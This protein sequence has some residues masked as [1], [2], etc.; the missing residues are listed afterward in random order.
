MEGVEWSE[1]ITVV[2]DESRQGRTTSP[3]T[4]LPL[5]DQE[6]SSARA[7]AVKVE[8]TPQAKPQSGLD[9]AGVVCEELVEGRD[10][11]LRR[12]LP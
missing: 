7:V 12:P 8:N 5:K 1:A 6:S 3:L 9:R 2:R 10:H 11:A 4:G